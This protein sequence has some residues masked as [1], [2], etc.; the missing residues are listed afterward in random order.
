MQKLIKKTD[1]DK[2]ISTLEGWKCIDNKKGIEKTFKFTNFNQAFSFM[3]KCAL[4]SEE[5]NHH[6]EWTNVYNLVRIKLT[7][8]DSGGLTALDVSLA[9]YINKIGKLK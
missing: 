5:M 1:I 4:K 6:P 8:H 3:Q 7:T 9:K 2:I